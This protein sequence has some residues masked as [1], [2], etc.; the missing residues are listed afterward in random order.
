MPF[1]ILLLSCLKHDRTL[2]EGKAKV[3]ITTDRRRSGEVYLFFDTLEPVGGRSPLRSVPFQCPGS[4]SSTRPAQSTYE[5]PL[6]DG[7]VLHTNNEHDEKIICLVELKTSRLEGAEKQIICTRKFLEKH[8][9][10]NT[11]DKIIW[12]A[13]VHISGGSPKDLADIGRELLK[14]FKKG[15][16]DI[17]K[18]E[19]LE[20]ILS[21]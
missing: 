19:N 16:F 17:S 1:S 12:R 9:R 15:N 21:F 4:N 14:E 18:K 11:Y 10:G 3:S 5:G 20:S 2:E 13:H 7:I 6:C 8:M